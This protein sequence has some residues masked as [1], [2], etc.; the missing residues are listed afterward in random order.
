MVVLDS[1]GSVEWAIGDSDL[2]IFPRSCNK[3][4]QGLGM[5][6]LGLRIEGPQ[7]AVAVAS[8]SGEPFHLEAVRAIL[9]GS[10]LGESDLQTPPDFPLDETARVE[11]LR[12]G[13]NKSPVAM[14][15]SG[16]HAA[17]LATCVVN[18]W[19]TASY[20]DPDHPLQR[21]LA[22]TFSKAVGEPIVATGVDGCGAPLFSAS[23]CGLARAF[24]TLIVAR[25]GSP[26]RRV[27]DAI[28]AFPEYVSGSR[29]DE[30]ALLR[31]LPG[32]IAKAGAEACYAVALPDGRAVALKVDDGH[33]R[34][35][36]VVMAAVLARMGLD[37][38]A[39]RATGDAPLLGGTAEVGRL[40]SAL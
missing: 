11:Y 23:L 25:P 14:N 24:R 12:A 40:R 7:L 32:A 1:D 30:A 4:I 22:S 19:P 10:G 18:G 34:A 39:V 37:S 26:E 33:P 27:A 28:I 6:R 9:A 20:R 31:A 29:R 15:C 35:R 13:L 38:E 17:M 16:K 5:V 36:P 8:H 21:A 3:P 2:P